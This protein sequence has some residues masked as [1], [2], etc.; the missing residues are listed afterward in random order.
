[1]FG[2]PQHILDHQKR[3]IV[4]FFSII[5]CL[6]KPNNMLTKKTKYRYKKKQYSTDFTDL[7]ILP[8]TILIDFCI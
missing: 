8:I 5:V 2:P 6:A 1:M 7:L 4:L 3:Q